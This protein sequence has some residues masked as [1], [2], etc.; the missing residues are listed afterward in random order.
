MGLF[1]PY[2]P[3]KPAPKPAQATTDEPA[4]AAKATTKAAAGSTRRPAGKSE[5]TP[6]RREAEAARR[7]RINPVRTKKEARA[8]EREQRLKLQQRRT[9]ELEARPEL[10]LMRDHIDARWNVAEFMLPVMLVMLALSLLGNRW[11]ILV[12]VTMVGTWSLLALVIV[13]I[14]VMWRGYRRLLAERLPRSS[15][16][17]LL[18][19]AVNRAM[20]IRRFRQP[21]ARIKRGASY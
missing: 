6:T 10:V 11:P 4:P 19:L 14:W 1:R 8:Y 15:S 12:L 13:D 21:P 7:Q 2:E 18:M 20:Q 17:G 5:R 16:K 3:S 9:S